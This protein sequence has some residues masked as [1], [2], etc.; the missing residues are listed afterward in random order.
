MEVAGRIRKICLP[1][2]ISYFGQ[3]VSADMDT[4]AERVPAIVYGQCLELFQD[5]HFA[6]RAKLPTECVPRQGCP[7]VDGPQRSDQR[8]VAP[9]LS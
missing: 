5:K 4:A 1:C 6:R 8:I 2:H 3:R 7:Y 9:V